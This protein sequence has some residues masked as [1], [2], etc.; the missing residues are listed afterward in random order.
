[1]HDNLQNEYG[2]KAPVKNEYTFLKKEEA[3]LFF[4][5]NNQKLSYKIELNKKE[6]I[7]YP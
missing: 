4:T 2:N 1:M 6:S 7:Y 3:I 5:Q